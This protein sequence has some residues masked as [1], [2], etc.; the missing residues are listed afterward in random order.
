MAEVVELGAADLRVEVAAT[1]RLGVRSSEQ[2][3]VQ[4]FERPNSSTQ[5]AQAVDPRTRFR[6]EPSRERDRAA[7]VSI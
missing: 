4:P 2:E 7:A 5:C 6:V 1:A 3:L